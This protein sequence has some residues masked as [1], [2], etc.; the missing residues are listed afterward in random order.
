MRAP[1]WQIS[2]A[3]HLSVELRKLSD[4]LFDLM[5]PFPV[6]QGFLDCHSVKRGGASAVACWSRKKEISFRRSARVF[7]FPAR[8][9]LEARLWPDSSMNLVVRD[10]DNS[11]EPCA[12][13]AVIGG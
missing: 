9:I 3:I 7:D 13:L 5:M 8:G 6:F 12:F 1:V 4:Q 10:L 11:F 2:L